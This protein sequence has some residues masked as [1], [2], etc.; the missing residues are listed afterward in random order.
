MS[1]AGNFYQH[2]DFFPDSENTL[3]NAWGGDDGGENDYDYDNDDNVDDD[4]GH[5]YDEDFPPTPALMPSMSRM[6]FDNIPEWF[7]IAE[8]VFDDLGISSDCIRTVI[9]MQSTTFSI[10]RLF[11]DIYDSEQ[12]A[13]AEIEYPQLK[14]VILLRSEQLEDWVIAHSASVLNDGTATLLNRAIGGLSSPDVSLAHPSLADKAEL[15]VGEDI[16][17]D[18]LPITIEL[19]SQTTVASDPHK[20]ARWNTRDVNWQALLEAVEESE[21]S[22][23]VQDMNLSQ[24]YLSCSFE[25]ACQAPLHQ[26][27][28]TNN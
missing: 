2:D 12:F 11:E 25:S 27:S 14:E 7:H 22:F 20:R 5:D 16:S 23:P 6:Y 21:R 17:S 26:R 19:C 13:Q 24:T 4:D 28:F 18:H 15:T 8:A 3:E 10:K 9:L 1:R